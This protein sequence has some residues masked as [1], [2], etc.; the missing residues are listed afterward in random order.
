VLGESIKFAAKSVD[1]FGGAAGRESKLL[2][3]GCPPTL[4]QM[5]HLALSIF[6]ARKNLEDG[7]VWCYKDCAPRSLMLI[8]G[9]SGFK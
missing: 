9:A 2:I 6:Q 7:Y 5:I 4:Q 8:P 1:F 3:H